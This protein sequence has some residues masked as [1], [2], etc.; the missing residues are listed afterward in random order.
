MFIFFCKEDV[1]NAAVLTGGS[2]WTMSCTGHVQPGFSSPADL[3][4][5]VL[6]STSTFVLYPQL[7]PLLTGDFSW[8]F[9]SYR[10]CQVRVV[11][12]SLF[13]LYSP[14]W[15]GALSMVFRSVLP[16]MLF[17]CGLLIPPMEACSQHREE[18]EF[19]LIMPSS[20]THKY[21]GSCSLHM[22][23]CSMSPYW[24]Q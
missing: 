22:C 21:L 8:W 24:H 4:V 3:A 12:K 14:C 18:S 1:C 20:F 11:W 5:M 15:V 23:A 10:S 7:Q 19:Q 6:P 9:I 16:G 2:T 17:C 13:Q